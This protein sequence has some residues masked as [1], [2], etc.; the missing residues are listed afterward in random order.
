M[1]F[2]PSDTFR[3]Y[4]HRYIH[5]SSGKIGKHQACFNQGGMKMTR[6]NKIA[7]LATG[8]IAGA[9][10]GATA[11]VLFAPKH[12]K[13][14]RAIIRQQSAGY[15]GA[16]RGRFRGS[17]ATGGAAAPMDSPTVVIDTLG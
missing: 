12:G 15:V 8:V 7:P 4:H 9:L 17:R 5:T 11:G 13:E 6:N 14:T 3:W 16:L 10:A 1:S 2:L